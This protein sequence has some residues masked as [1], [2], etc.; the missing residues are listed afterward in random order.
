MTGDDRGSLSAL[1]DAK[2]V[3]MIGVSTRAGSVGRQALRTLRR[4]RFAGDVAIVHPRE[5]EID[6]TP[7]YRTLDAV[8]FAV[9]LVMVFTPAAGVVEVLERC[10]RE[11]VGAAIVFSSGFADVGDAALADGL[12]IFLQTNAIRVL[13]PNCQGIINTRSQLAAS[14]TNAASAKVLGE[15]TP[16]GYVGQSGALGGS[17]FD[18]LRE[19]GLSPSFWASS[20]NQVDVSVTELAQWAVRERVVEL[21]IIY[22]EQVPPADEL[23]DLGRSASEAGL[24]L[25]VVRSGVSAAG[26]AAVASHTG[27]LVP[28]DKAFDLLCQE[29]GILVL[30]DLSQA[31]D[32]ATAW[33]ARLRGRGVGI[34]TTSGG[35]GS[36][37][38]DALDRHGLVVS[39]LATT[40]G[41]ALAE[42]LPGFAALQNP[43]D[44]TAQLLLTEPGR[45][46]EVCQIVA[47]DKGVDHVLVV[48]TVV[49]GQ[50]ARGF[51]EAV[52][53]LRMEDGVSVSVV[54]LASHDR[55][56]EVR[57]MLAAAGVPVF[58][59]LETAARA[60][61]GAAPVLDGNHCRTNRDDSG[62]ADELEIVLSEW[63]GREILDR[64]RVPRPAGELATS[65]AEAVA[66][67]RRLPGPLVFKVQSAALTH[68]SEA[69]GIR[70]RVDPERAAQTYREMIDSVRALAGDI[71]IDGVLV[72]QM[73]SG[74]FE[75]LVGVQ[76]PRNG[77]PPVVTVG[78]GGVTVEIHAD[79]SSGLAPLDH[80]G[81][82]RLLRSLRSWP[83]F[84]GFR[85]RAPL[86]HQ[87][88]AA[89]VAA[90]SEL[91]ASFGD[92]LIDLEVNPLL[93]G[94]AGTG[95]CAADFVLRLRAD[96]E[97]DGRV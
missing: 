37:A 38:A 69:G 78:A 89:A 44:V 86:D 55:T 31:V 85:G 2:S 54:Y 15:P 16:I 30:E 24:R 9:E 57:G 81:A 88:A 11:G 91:G 53:R 39:S 14:F 62:V 73:F 63:R 8:P 93:V 7:A 4:F 5:S 25:V 29:L 40:T 19:R 17:V 21:L 33:Q 59:G 50:I 75:L 74:Q 47:R 68:K 56:Q 76:G 96:A 80:D 87:A 52:S 43:V 58:D 1:L 48:I 22:L 82:E 61:S 3:V 51:A 18:L 66:F 83:L 97:E 28:T 72:Q 35:A 64:H 67:A 32:L 95:S 10:V 27:S 94:S 92:R 90:I 13:G 84:A 36:L 46:R 71:A 26:R 79:V 77:Y 70:L 42:C 12:R 45:F 60:L 20:G 49:V 23:R 65:E 6:G 41:A 34:V